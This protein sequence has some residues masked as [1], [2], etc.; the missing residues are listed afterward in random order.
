MGTLVRLLLVFALVGPVCVGARAAELDGVQLPPTL[1]ANGKTLRLNGFGLRTFSPLRLRIYVAA[2]Y[3]EQLNTD[4]DAILASPETKLLAVTFVRNVSA[5]SARK[6]WRDG[7]E[8]NCQAPCH[9]DPT[10]LATF[11]NDVPAMHA[12]DRF[13]LVFTPEGATVSLNGQPMG[14]V[15]HPQF[16]EAMLATFLGPRPGSRRLK[17]EL[18]A[19]RSG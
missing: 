13:F 17:R 1:P 3:L 15:S 19:G 11:L 4:P 6:S 5:N 9:L 7:L 16:A 12:G 10:D 18:L 14:T 8:N 2:L